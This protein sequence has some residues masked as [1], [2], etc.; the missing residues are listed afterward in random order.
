[1]K[2]TKKMRFQSIADFIRENDN[3]ILTAHETPDG[4]AIGSE[5]AAYFAL[6]SI[7]KN[8]RIINADPM[9]EKYY[10]LDSD[11]VIELY[12]ESTVLQENFQNW[13]LIILDTNDIN[14]IGQVKENV[15]SKVKDFFIFDH[16]EGGDSVL[17]ANHIES[18]ASSTCEMLYELF[19]EMKIEMTYEMLVAIYLGIV[20]DTGS[21]I[22]PKTTARTF[23]IAEDCVRNGVNP[24]FIYSKLYESNSISSLMLQSKVLSTLE[25]F[26]EKHVAVQTM[27]KEDIIKSGALYE[28]ADSLINIPLKS[29]DIKVSIFF[30]ENLEGILRC[31]MRSKGNID[32]AFIAQIFNGGGHKTAA[33][34]KSKYPL[35]EIKVKV[36]DMLNKY[37]V[38]PGND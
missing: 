12:E 38:Q 7:G 1:M 15:L 32:V 3:I 11:N 30:K 18:E 36:L 8:I 24:N 21:F 20:Y 10:F 34:F 19:T 35:E 14:N 13:V 28:E 16:H 9:A 37:F 17:T 6:K 23:A 27:L 22:Y 31:S 25:F 4:D 33:G 5:I 2:D 29:E 26:Y